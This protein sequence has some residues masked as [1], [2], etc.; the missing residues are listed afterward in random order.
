[1]AVGKNGDVFSLQHHIRFAYCKGPVGGGEHGPAGP[2]K[3]KVGRANMAAQSEGG[4]FRL[5][6]VARH[7]HGHAGEHLHHAHIFEYLVGGAIFAQSEARVRGAD[8]YIFIGVGDGLPDLVVYPAGGEVG[9][10]S[11]EGDLAANGHAGS[12]AHHVGFG[13]AY[14]E[15][16]VGEFFLKGIH[17]QGAGE[18]GT[19]AYHVFI[20]A[21]QF[22]QASPEAG[23][24]ILFVGEGEFGHAEWIVPQLYNLSC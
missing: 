13:N 16:A 4:G 23:A 12:N 15:K 11:R 24:C 17:F 14:L 19:E 1:M 3:A 20:F 22:E 2:S 6:V 21:A 9:E 5:V 18:V 8:F 10:C 7:D